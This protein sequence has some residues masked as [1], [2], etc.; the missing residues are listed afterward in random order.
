MLARVLPV[1]CLRAA[2]PI[3]ALLLVCLGTISV[4]AFDEKPKRK[5]LVFYPD[6]DSRPGIL[7]FDRELRKSLHDAESSI[8]IF[9]EFL[10]ASRF[11]DETYQQKLA[12]FLRSKYS[13][14]K[15]DVVVAAL[16]PSL[17][18]VL[19]YRSMICPGVPVVYGVIDKNEFEARTLD[20]DVLGTPMSYAME[21]TL[22]LA[23]QLQQ[24]AD[25]GIGGG[26]GLARSQA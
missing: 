22:K 14:N 3:L 5:V 9:N 11:P 21:P 18:F 20:K 2:E 1:G 7:V 10:D 6:S 19:R 26:G 12:S 24:P 4:S 25:P 15:P 13:M 16:S 23:L 8:E 17:D